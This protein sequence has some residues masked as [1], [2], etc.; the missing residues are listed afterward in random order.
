MRV[1]VA[2]RNP[3]EAIARNSLVAPYIWL[4]AALLGVA[5]AVIFRDS[6]LII[7]IM[8]VVET[9]LYLLCYRALF[10]RRFPAFL[11]LRNTRYTPLRRAYD[12]D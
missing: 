7:G 8:L 3:D 12:P 4:M 11:V 10:K 6:P 5:P 2:T 9:V 1:F